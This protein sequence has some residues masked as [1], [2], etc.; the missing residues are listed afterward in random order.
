MNNQAVVA[1]VQVGRR[2]D[3]CPSA[4]CLEGSKLARSIVCFCS[5]LVATPS[6]PI[7]CGNLEVFPSEKRANPAAPQLIDH[8]ERV[9]ANQLG[10]ICPRYRRFT[11]G[12]AEWL[13]LLV[14]TRWGHHG[15]KDHLADSQSVVD[16]GTRTPRVWEKLCLVTRLVTSTCS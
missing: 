15:R 3:P 6:W 4:N 5:F 7:E 11:P 8:P 1:R 9:A 13:V 14:V 2:G 10:V 12:K 16:G